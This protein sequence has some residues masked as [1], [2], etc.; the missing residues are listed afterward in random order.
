MIYT[1]QKRLDWFQN[2]SA[3]A[4]E[5]KNHCPAN[6]RARRQSLCRY[7]CNEETLCGFSTMV[8]LQV[9]KARKGNRAKCWQ[10]T[11][12]LSMQLAVCVTRRC[13]LPV[14]E[15]NGK[16]IKL[17]HRPAH[18]ELQLPLPW[19]CAT[20]RVSFQLLIPCWYIFYTSGDTK[21]IGKQLIT[22][23]NAINSDTQYDQLKSVLQQL[24]K[25]L[26]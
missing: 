3:I 25:M 5:E 20:R 24:L 21:N 8:I 12:R 17:Q 15:S 9:P 26:Q 7:N 2:Q 10:W 6:E 23:V 16:I 13:G 4:G 1:P 19:A 14:S 11:Q 22:A 18:I